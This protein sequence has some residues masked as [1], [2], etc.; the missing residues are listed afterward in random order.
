MRLYLKEWPNKSASIMFDNGVTLFTCH[1]IESARS[2]LRDWY[3]Y[4][5]ENES[6]DN[7]FQDLTC[8][9]LC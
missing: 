8:S 2:L 9:T 7:D 3:E 5:I 4:Q 6:P 1:D